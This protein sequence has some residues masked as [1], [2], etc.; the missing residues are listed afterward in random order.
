MSILFVIFFNANYL[1]DSGY[2]VF[3]LLIFPGVLIFKATDRFFMD[4]RFGVRMC[5]AFTIGVVWVTVAGLFS[6]YILLNCYGA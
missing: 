1:L 3:I 5:L 6:Y 2:K 4:I